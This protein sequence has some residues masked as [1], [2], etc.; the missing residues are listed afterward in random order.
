[1]HCD[2]T[3][4]QIAFYEIILA[5]PYRILKGE[6]A[7]FFS[8]PVLDA[9]I[10]ARADD[11]PHL[12]YVDLDIT[13]SSISTLVS[14]DLNTI[15]WPMS[16]SSTVTSN[17]SRLVNVDLLNSQLTSPHWST[18]IPCQPSSIS[19]STIHVDLHR[20]CIIWLVLEENCKSRTVTDLL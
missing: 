6:E 9:C 8:V 4:L 10:I 3:D 17:I 20:S 14:I 1:M 18:S 16:T 19:C 2:G 7:D 12:I 15:Q 13:I 5:S 11:A